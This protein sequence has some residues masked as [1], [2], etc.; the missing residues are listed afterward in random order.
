MFGEE[1]KKRGVIKLNIGL[2]YEEKKIVC[3]KNIIGCLNL[4]SK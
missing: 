3:R 1:L 4:G 2:V